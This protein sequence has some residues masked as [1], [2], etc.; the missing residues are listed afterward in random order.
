[1]SI[2]SPIKLLFVILTTFHFGILNGQSPSKDLMNREGKKFS[3]SEINKLKNTTTLFVLR[4][5][6]LEQKEEFEAAI[7]SIWDF[8]EL[9]FIPLSEL[10]EHLEDDNYSC[11]FIQGHNK[12]YSGEYTSSNMTY[13]YLTLLDGENAYCRIELFPDYPTMKR[14]TD[15]IDNNA[16]G[17]IYQESTIK[18]WT[19]AHLSMYLAEV[20][21]NL[22]NA[23]RADLNESV[24]L[25]K[26]QNFSKEDILY[27]PEYVKYKYNPWDGS[28]AEEYD[29][30]E[31]FKDCPMTVEIISM[32]SLSEKIENQEIDYIFDYV[33]SSNIVFTGFYS[34]NDGMMCRNMRAPAYNL[35]SKDIKKMFK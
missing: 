6:D 32:S 34:L 8:T 20:Q 7:N 15:N 30:E 16:L 29:M 26:H 11:F 5:Q 3:Q 9:V 17:K 4:D 25:N 12:H 13:L 19:P 1:M 31:L 27:V 22:K 24:R 10:E 21:E 18:N 23:I 2:C 28:E 33:K 14:V 35:K